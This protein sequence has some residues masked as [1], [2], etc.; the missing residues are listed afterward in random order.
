MS[1]YSDKVNN[2]AVHISLENVQNE[3][4]SIREKNLIPEAIE[5]I[6][7][8]TLVIKNFSIS[9]ENCNKELIAITWLEDASKA[10]ENIKS[11]LVSY[12][13]N[14][15]VNTLRNNS[16]SQIDILLHTSVKLNCVKS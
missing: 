16:N 9:I 2:H 8:I 4:K 14:K 3:L 10:L 15:D 11:Y 7:R 1:T 5:V 13:S 6:A 12:N